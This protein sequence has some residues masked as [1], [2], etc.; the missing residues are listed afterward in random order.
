MASALLPAAV[1]QDARVIYAWCRRADDAVDF[2]P[3]N[4]AAGAVERLSLELDGV[5]RGDDLSDPVL[6]AFQEVVSRRGIPGHYPQELLMGMDMDV[7]KLRY[8]TQDDLALY[9]YRVA[10]TVGL[11]MCHVMG[12]GTPTAVQ[13]ACHLG[14]GMQLTNICR[15]VN[16]DWGR[17][18]L[19]LPL[20]LLERHGSRLL[21]PTLGQPLPPS[22]REP[23]ARAMQSLL[24]TAELY[25]RSGDQGAAFLSPRCA[26]AVRAARHIYSAIG[27][28]L[29][30]ADYNVFAPRAHTSKWT[31]LRL[32]AKAAWEVAINPHAR[33][34][35][36]SLPL[37]EYRDVSVV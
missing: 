15:D 1:R 10:G 23:M 24:E 2:A 28:Q 19:Y 14:I 29:K 7:R 4:L 36:E 33:S 34:R 31:K 11:M 20:E 21:R 16:E 18:R 13:Q 37:L 22:E 17:G 5:Y 27:G 8:E 30:R 26:L 3:E 25:Y 12:L 6:A 32:V 9:C 35:S